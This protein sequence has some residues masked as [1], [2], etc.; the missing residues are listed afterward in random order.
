LAGPIL[1]PT[2]SKHATGGLALRGG[3][4]GR[5]RRH[6]LAHW[7]VHHI[8]AWEDDDVRWFRRRHQKAP[9]EQSGPTPAD[10]DAARS[11]LRNFVQTRIGVEMYVEPR[12]SVTPTTLVL[13]AATGEWTRRR[14]GSPQAAGELARELGVPVYDVQQTGYP[15]RMREWTSAQRRPES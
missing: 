15:G 11:H 9:A 1:S 3:N 8:E 10:V 14:I 4:V 13:V 5:A 6:P 7:D 2:G 12:T